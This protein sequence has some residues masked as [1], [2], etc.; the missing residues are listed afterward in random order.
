MSVVVAKIGSSSL[1][2][3]SGAIVPEAIDKLCAEVAA[4]R[5]AGHRVVIGE[6]VIRPGPSARRERPADPGQRKGTRA[7]RC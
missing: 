3:S 6:D 7:L 5:T 2:D 4:L 1:T